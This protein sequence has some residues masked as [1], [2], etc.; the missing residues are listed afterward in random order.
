MRQLVAGN[1]WLGHGDGAGRVRG[2]VDGRT[3]EFYDTRAAGMNTI[4]DQGGDCDCLTH[5]AP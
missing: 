3:I 4:L 1:L 2:V 5:F